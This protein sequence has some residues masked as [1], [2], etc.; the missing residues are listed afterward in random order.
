MGTIG[1]VGEGAGTAAWPE[2]AV[3]EGTRAAPE[4]ACG[5]VAGSAGAFRG[6]PLVA[7]CEGVLSD[8][9][10]APEAGDAALGT[11]LGGAKG[12]VGSGTLSTAAA[13]GC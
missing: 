5:L 12:A 10:V 2:A 11:S 13:G 6:T 9:A 3:T 1:A 8:R 4:P 7:A